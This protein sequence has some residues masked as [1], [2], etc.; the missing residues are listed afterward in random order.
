MAAGVRSL[1]DS[2]YGIAISGI[3][4]PGGATMHKPVGLIWFGLA[5]RDG[6][7]AKK[8][9][10]PFDRRRNK[11]ASAYMGLDILRRHLLASRGRAAKK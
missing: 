7:S 6:V 5:T 8:V 10:L 2:D 9:V 11:V 4:G 1:C 3:A